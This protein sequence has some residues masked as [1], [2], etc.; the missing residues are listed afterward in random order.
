MGIHQVRE[1]VPLDLEVGSDSGVDL[2][3]SC[4]G[5]DGLDVGAGARGTATGLEQLPVF[6]AAGKTTEWTQLS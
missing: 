2:E 6:A 5:C 1:V 3:V 4:P